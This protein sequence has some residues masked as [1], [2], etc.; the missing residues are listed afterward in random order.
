MM[1]YLLWNLGGLWAETC[2]VTRSGSKYPSSRYCGLL[3]LDTEND[4]ETH[5]PR[6]HVSKQHIQKGVTT[7]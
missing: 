4:L 2:A 1:W 7:K 5:T 6:V 3:K